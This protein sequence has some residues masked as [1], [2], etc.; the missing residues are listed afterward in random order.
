MLSGW[1]FQFPYDYA[2]KSMHI[3]GKDG[4]RLTNDE[5]YGHLQR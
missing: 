2:C 3:N 5:L 1:E 4:K